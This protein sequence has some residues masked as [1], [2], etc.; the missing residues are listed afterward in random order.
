M[1]DIL[2]L[3]YSRYGATAAM[4]ERV[5]RGIE[6]VAGV[7]ARLRT[8]P[9]VS[10][11][12][13][14]VEDA[15][16]ESGPVYATHSD[17]TE[18][19][20]LVMGSPTRFGNMAAPLKYFLDGTA[21]LWL[22]GTLSGKPAGVFTSTSTLHGGQES[23]LLSMMLPLL[24][25]G[26]LITGVPYTERELNTTRS[27]GTPYGPSHLAGTDSRLA[28]TADEAALCRALGKRIAEIAS[29]LNTP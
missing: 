15:I 13:E 5:C 21:S 6:E 28:V 22:N 10:A 25:H 8:V 17:L 18:C 24:H 27:G 20:G 26:M 11:A 14:A 29:K 2:V 16:P 19:A 23:T 7:Q 4:A 1:S 9:R 12:C 3:Y